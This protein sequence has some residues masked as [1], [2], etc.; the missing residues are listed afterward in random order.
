MQNECSCL[1]KP[2]EIEEKTWEERNKRRVC[3]TEEEYWTL[4]TELGFL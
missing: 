4:V 3:E 2:V 1:K